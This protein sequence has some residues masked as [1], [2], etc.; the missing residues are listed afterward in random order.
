MM[1]KIFVYGTLKQGDFNHVILKDKKA[2]I[3]FLGKAKTKPEFTLYNLEKFPGMVRGGNTS[4]SGEIYKVDDDILA[5]LDFLEGY[6]PTKKWNMYNRE[7]IELEGG[8][9]IESYI[10]PEENL[11]KNDTVIESGHWETFEERKK[12]QRH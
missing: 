11:R 10:F 5:Y 12:K 9:T 6:D 8:G 1:H 3:K 2:K 7:E 4:V